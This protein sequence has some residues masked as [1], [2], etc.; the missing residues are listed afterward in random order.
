M[1]KATAAQRNKKFAN[2]I[3]MLRRK[4]RETQKE[5]AI[6]FSDYMLKEEPIS[7]L[8]V[9]AWENGYKLPSINT[10]MYLCNYFGVTADYLLG[11]TDDPGESSPVKREEFSRLPDY[12]IDPKD[13]EKYSKEPVFVVFPNKEYCNRWGFLDYEKRR[14]LFSDMIMKLDG[15]DCE[16]YTSVPDD[17]K[18][19]DYSKKKPYSMAQLLE[20]SKVWVN[21]LSADGYIKGEYNGWYRH[22]ENHTA[23]VNNIGLVLPYEG[24]NISYSVYP[25]EV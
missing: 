9:S 16:Y 10:T 15:Y 4:N 6:K 3:A 17:E 21:M 22:N 13:L 18:S 2:R 12:H 23:L 14:V 25:S 20:A 7:P 19:V 1:L 11:L 24:L 5:F 8:T